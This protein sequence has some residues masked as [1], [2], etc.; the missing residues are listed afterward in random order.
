MYAVFVIGVALWGIYGVMIA[1]T[2]VIAANAITL[3]LASV[4][5][6]QKV[7]HVRAGQG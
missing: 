3:L 7:R 6:F 1:S 4:I 2:P 5:L